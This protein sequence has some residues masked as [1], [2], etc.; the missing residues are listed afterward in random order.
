MMCLRRAPVKYIAGAKSP[1]GAALDRA[2][3]QASTACYGDSFIFV[4]CI[5]IY[6]YIYI[7][8]Y[9]IYIHTHTYMECL[10]KK[11]TMLFQMLL[12]DECYE[13]LLSDGSFV[14]L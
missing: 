7:C 8:I 6:I 10:K 12:C 5:H 4:F 2:A 9:Y 11:F 1:A 14:R 13:N 3:L